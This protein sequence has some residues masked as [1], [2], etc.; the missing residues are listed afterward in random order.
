MNELTT[1]EL[2]AHLCIDPALLRKWKMQGL[3]APANPGAPCLRWNVDEIARFIARRKAEKERNHRSA[4]KRRREKMRQDW[5]EIYGPKRAEK[6]RSQRA[7]NVRD[8]EP[9]AETA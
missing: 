2:A 4:V 3:I 1:T 8:P 9:T 7:E 6:I 5:K